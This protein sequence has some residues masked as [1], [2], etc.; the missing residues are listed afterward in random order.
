MNKKI[1]LKNYTPILIIFLLISIF[2]NIYSYLNINKYKYKLGK[3]SQINIEDI[4][5]RNESNMNILNVSIGQ[6]CIKNEDLLK[7]YKNYDIIT[8]EI[9]E[10]WGQYAS[11]KDNT[12]SI[13]S[14]NIDD[15]KV[16]ENDVYLRIKDY[17]SIIL[18]QTMKSKDIGLTLSSGYLENFETMS[19]LTKK[20]NSYFEE[21][22]SQ[23]L[24]NVTGEQREKEII[25][26]HYWID[27]LE[28]IYNINNDYTNIEFNVDESKNVNNIEIMNEKK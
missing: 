11:Y 18:N 12:L 10:L 23:K 6:G 26:N 7:L 14:K 17:L 25:K 16:L 3:E 4:R 5:Q 20:V 28:G 22:N 21:F 2:I 27:M 19:E 15:K 1:K 24:L 9:I 13:F 8:S